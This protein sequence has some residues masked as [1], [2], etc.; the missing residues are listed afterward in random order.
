VGNAP[1]V[2]P[3]GVKALSPATN[4]PCRQRQRNLVSRDKDPCPQR[5]P[6]PILC[7]SCSLINQMD[8]TPMPQRSS[9]FARRP[10][11][12]YSTPSWVAGAIAGRLTPCARQRRARV[13][14]VPASPYL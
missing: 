13:L 8:R 7:L 10:G 9:G 1:L 4:L 11:D 6:G 12:D 2:F 3:G 14:V 5:Q